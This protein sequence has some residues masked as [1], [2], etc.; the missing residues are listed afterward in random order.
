MAA[1]KPSLTVRFAAEGLVQNEMAAGI[2]AERIIVGGFSQ[3]GHVALKL[4][5]GTKHRLAGCIACSTWIEFAANSANQQARCP[6]G[7]SVRPSPIPLSGNPSSVSSH[8]SQLW[9]VHARPPMWW[10]SSLDPGHAHQVQ[11]TAVSA[12]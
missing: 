1:P 8:P 6:S 7:M 3:G 5:L 11:Q 12:E 4:L 10:N 2:P 9:L